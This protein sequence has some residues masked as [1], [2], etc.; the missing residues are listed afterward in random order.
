MWN[1]PNCCPDFFWTGGQSGYF[2]LFNV[3]SL[4]LKSVHPKLRVGGPATGIMCGAR[5]VGCVMSVLLSIGNSLMRLLAMSSWI[6]EFLT[7]CKQNHVPFDFIS[8]HEYPTDPP[9][10]QTRTF[11]SDHLRQTRDTVGK[12]IPIYYTEYDDGYNDATSYSAAF[13]V[14]QQFMAQGIVDALSWWPFTDI[15]E[16]AG[17]YPDPYNAQW[18]PVDGL[19]NVYGIPKPSYRAFQLLHWSGT[20]LVDTIPNTFHSNNETVGVFAVTGNHTS[21]FIVNWN[22]MHQTISQE[23]VDVVVTGVDASTTTATGYYIDTQHTNS[24]PM[25]QQMGSPLYLSPKQVHQLKE[26]STLVAQQ[27]PLKVV[28]E[29]TVRFSVTIEPQ[30]VINVILM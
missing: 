26:A 7:F 13:A 3:T 8:T 18:M 17:L 16:E 19:M 30:A 5:S 4:A 29:R 28:D 6:P 21:I 23:I 9:G 1:E 24:F 11:F 14:Y 12:D 10:P 22:I 15:F 25:W 20:S 27:I 2:T